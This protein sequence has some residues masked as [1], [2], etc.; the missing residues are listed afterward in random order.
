M[1]NKENVHPRNKIQLSR[2]DKVF[3]VINY[4]LAIIFI[5][6]IVY[7]L[8]FVVIASFSDPNEVATGNVILFPKNINLKGYTELFKDDLFWRSYWN[9]I[10]YTFVGTFIALAVNIT[11][12]FALTRE[13]LVG[14]K[15]IQIFYL[16]PMFF[17]GGLIPTYLTIKDYGM[18]NTFWVMVIPFAVS[19]YNIIVIRSY[20]NNSE[21]KD[22]SEAAQIDGCGTIRYF[23][24]ILLPLSKAIIAVIGLWTA[25]ALWND[26]FN[27][28]I[29]LD[30]ETK[31]PLQL[32]LRRIL[33]MGESLEGE[34]TGELGV[35]LR[36]TANMMKYSSIVISTLPI[37]ILYP[38]IQRHLD[39]GALAGALKG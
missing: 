26:W 7:P 4:G 22:L 35:E 2:S 3:N 8:W 23:F 5:L 21:V 6:I 15:V 36:K 18:L 16:I 20:F 17:G 34:A 25:V 11:A 37:M 31:R 27:G 9:T 10:K 28:L 19:S 1:A 33:I 38:L 32:L 29:Y 30:D 14:K 24:Q 13:Y 39:Q 12:G